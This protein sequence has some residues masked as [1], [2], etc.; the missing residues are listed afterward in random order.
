MVVDKLIRRGLVPQG[1]WIPSWLRD[2]A[3]KQ[4]LQ[5]GLFSKP[6]KSIF[7]HSLSLTRPPDQR[8]VGVLPSVA[9]PKKF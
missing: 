6:F 8:T 3:N 9:I 2:R 5:Q 4:F 1:V 7:S